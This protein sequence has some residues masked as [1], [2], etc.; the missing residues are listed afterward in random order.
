M[1][2]S[3]LVHS[4]SI[5]PFDLPLH[6]LNSN[7]MQQQ[8]QQRRHS[9][10]LSSSTSSIIDS[11][12]V[13]LYAQLAALEQQNANTSSIESNRLKSLL[14]TYHYSC[15]Q[16]KARHKI[17]EERID[18]RFDLETRC[19]RAHFAAKKSELKEI[20]LDRLRRKRK[21]VVDE[22]RSAIDI[23]SRS[24]DADP[25]LVTMQ[26]PHPL[27]AKAYNFRQR[28]DMG[29]ATS[30]SS[31]VNDD[32]FSALLTMN[33]IG[34]SGILSPLPQQQAARKRLVGA[35]SIFQLPKWTVKDDECED[36]LRLI[37]NSRK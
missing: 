21:L 6:S 33:N 26:P 8:R 12:L 35:F 22:M 5:L 13:T 29:Q 18:R 23:H 3:S 24:F 36:D 11:H 20:L 14:E 32:E 10:R 7:T 15:L 1:N 31:N 27:Q 25:L 16:L 2:R 19:T 28:P 34:T 4:N 30:S 9:H 17:E 37:T